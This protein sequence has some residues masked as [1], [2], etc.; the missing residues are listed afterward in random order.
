[1][2][3]T[4][5]ELAKRLMDGEKLY[6]VN[7][8]TKHYCFYGEEFEVPFKIYDIK[9]KKIFDMHSIWGETEW[10]A[11]KETP[12]YLEPVMG[13]KSYYID[14]NG[15]I[16]HSMSWNRDNDQYIIEQGSVFKIKEEAIKEI[17]LRA[18]K[19]RVKKRIWELNGEE[20]I[21]YKAN[22]DN[23][24]FD[25][26]GKKIFFGSWKTKFYPNWQYLKNE[27]LVEQLIHEMYDDLLLIRIE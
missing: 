4:K 22:N 11:H 8:S 21:G 3:L 13:E 27:K 14:N 9:S 25:I 17:K 1:M 6:A 10:E 24:S 18:S 7:Y 19:Y 12:K 23:Y 20:F 15:V 16:S 26:Y 2:E 5:K